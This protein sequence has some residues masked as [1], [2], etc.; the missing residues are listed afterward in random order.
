[1]LEYVCTYKNEVHLLK[2]QCRILIDSKLV[3]SFDGRTNT[4]SII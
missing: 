3:T 4:E 1:M 2:F